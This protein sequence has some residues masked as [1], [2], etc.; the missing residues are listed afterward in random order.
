[1]NVERVTARPKIRHAPEG[2]REQDVETR[3]L[4]EHLGLTL[5][6]SRVNA[7]A[8]RTQRPS[9]ICVGASPTHKPIITVTAEWD[10]EVAVDRQPTGL[11]IADRDKLRRLWNDRRGYTNAE[12]L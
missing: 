10:C 7:K 11:V 4:E 2:R 1:M 9:R 6:C 12:A 5:G 3:V 8:N